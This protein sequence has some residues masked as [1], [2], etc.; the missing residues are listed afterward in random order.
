MKKVIEKIKEVV[1]PQPKKETPVVT[2][3][4]PDMPEKK[5]RDLR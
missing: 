2:V 5:Q 3:R 4:D 1:K